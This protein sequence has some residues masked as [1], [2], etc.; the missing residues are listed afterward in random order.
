MYVLCEIKPLSICLVAEDD[1]E[2]MGDDGLLGGTTSVDDLKIAG[3]ISTSTNS[4]IIG[5]Q[6]FIFSI[7]FIGCLCFYYKNLWRF[8]TSF[9]FWWVGLVP[10]C[11][12]HITVEIPWTTRSHLAGG[13]NNVDSDVVDSNSGVVH[14][15]DSSNWGKRGD[16]TVDSMQSIK[17][18]WPFSSLNNT[19]C[20]L[21]YSD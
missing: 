3:N 2:I 20:Y 15:N 5:G 21:L 12:L 11:D 10:H 6:W 7:F 9:I 13:G 18:Q 16:R 8:S 19:D 4:S 17:A 14:K 1:D